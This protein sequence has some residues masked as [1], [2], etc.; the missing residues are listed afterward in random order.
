MGCKS[1][2]ATWRPVTYLLDPADVKG[3]ETF[4]VLKSNEM[5]R[6]RTARL[7]LQAWGRMQRRELAA[8]EWIASENPLG[9]VVRTEAQK[10][11]WDWFHSSLR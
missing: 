4:R 2:L 3:R 5:L 7:V 11:A 10:A 6:Y 8:A 9:F 1:A